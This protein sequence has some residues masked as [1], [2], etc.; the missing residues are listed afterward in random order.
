VCCIRYTSAA[1]R[2]LGLRFR[3]PPAGV[4]ICPVSVVC[5]QIEVCATSWLLVQRNSTDW[6]RRVWSR[7]L[8][9]EE[10]M[11]R[12][13]PRPHKKYILYFISRTTVTIDVTVRTPCFTLDIR[14]QQE[15]QQQ[16]VSGAR[17]LWKWFVLNCCSY[18]CVNKLSCD[19]NAR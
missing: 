15:Q 4:N 14:E 10:V 7:N 9:N 5:C 19:D 16:Y 8:I 2:L 13:G 1:A 3:I 17:G 12:I 6:L 18:V 11:V